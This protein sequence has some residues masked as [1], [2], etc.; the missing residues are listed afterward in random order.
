M[1]NPLMVSLGGDV[2]SFSLSEVERADLYGSRKRLPTDVDGRTCV[3]A[4]LTQDGNLLV[5]SGMSGQGYFNA[6]GQFVPRG[7][8][9]GIDPQ[10]NMVESQ[11]STLGLPQTL[12]GP[13]DPSIV[14]DLELLSV[15]LL[16]PEQEGGAL[17]DRLKAGEIYACS[18][19][20]AASLE[21]ERAY[22]LANDQGLFALVGKPVA[23]SWV[24][25][26]AL[27]APALEEAE[28]SDELDFEML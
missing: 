21:V 7:K 16:T 28:T 19:N 1:A 4:A 26:G 27:F 15:Y 23:I 9:V 8:L 2:M 17:I 22:L 18:F 10:G 11:P 20:Y 5:A 3:R 13:V 25:E 12:D 6:A 14:L 24:E